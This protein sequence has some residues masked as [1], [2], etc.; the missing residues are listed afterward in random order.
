V[1]CEAV[2]LDRFAHV[3]QD[4]LGRRDRGA[5]RGLEPTAERVQ[6]A[7]GA[8]AGVFVGRPGAPEGFLRFQHHVAGAGHLVRQVVGP[9]HT[10]N[11]GACY[12]HVEVFHSLL[13]FR[14]RAVGIV[15]NLIHGRSI[16][17]DQRSVRSAGKRLTDSRNECLLP[18][19]GCSS[20]LPLRPKTDIPSH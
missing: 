5:D 3:F 19:Q 6:I 14:R 10:G 11:A 8:D 20:Q 12:Y 18:E 9:A 7:I 2:F 17:L 15:D 1:F 4:F 13:L 16:D